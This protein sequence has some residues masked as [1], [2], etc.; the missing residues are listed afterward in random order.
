MTLMSC[1]RSSQTWTTSKTAFLVASSSAKLELPGMPLA[2]TVTSRRRWRLVP[3]TAEPRTSCQ[4]IDT[5]LIAVIIYE[6]RR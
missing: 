4:C 1:K 3:R 6:S 2:V 5:T